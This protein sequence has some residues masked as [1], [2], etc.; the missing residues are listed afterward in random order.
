VSGAPREEDAP[1][2]VARYEQLRRNAA[3]WRSLVDRLGL[4]VV[5]QQ[6]LAAWLEQWS[7]LPAPASAPPTMSSQP[8]LMPDDCNA[9]VIQVLAS[10]ALSHVKEVHV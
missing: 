9:D 4:M 1:A 3:A 10:M 5:L 2:H 8:T 7:K 6:G